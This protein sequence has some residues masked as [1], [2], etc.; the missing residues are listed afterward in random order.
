M[1]ATV[2]INDGDTHN[3]PVEACE[4]KTPLLIVQRT[5]GQDSGGQSIGAGATGIRWGEICLA[6]KE[7]SFVHLV[8]H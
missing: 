7:P 1:N 2:C 4:A 6:L 5:L 3:S 8:I